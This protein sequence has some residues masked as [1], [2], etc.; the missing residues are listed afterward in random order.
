MNWIQQNI[1]TFGGD[2]DRV[3]IFGESNGA[4]AVGLHITAYG[5]GHDDPKLKP[6]FQ[7]GIMQSGGAT[8][9]AGVSSNTSFIHTA[10]VMETLNCTSSP[11]NP[12][13]DLACLR[14]L[15]VST[16]LSAAVNFQLAT[17][18]PF[19]FNVF[20]PVAPT[21]FIPDAPSTLLRTGQFAHNI[22]I[23]SGWNEDDGSLFVPP[24][25]NL[26]SETPTVAW[27]HTKYPGLT[28]SQIHTLLSL[29]P[30]DTPSFNNSATAD[31]ASGAPSQQYFRAS[32]MD[33][34]SSFTCPSLLTVSN[35]ARYSTSPLGSTHLYAL[36]SSLL[37]TDVYKPY[38]R[39]YYGISH[40]SDIPFAFNQVQASLSPPPPPAD[41][42]LSS[43]ISGAWLDFAT[44]GDPN[45][46]APG[47][48][49]QDWPKAVSAAPS[50]EPSSYTVQIFGGLRNGQTQLDGYEN[51]LAARC[52]F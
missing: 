19:G 22:N 26:T 28:Q 36:N 50:S 47:H 52:A 43:R 44:F 51:E 5:G 3:T 30:T 8:Q 45:G 39:S 17:R 37:Y 13:Q 29:Y 49:A 6:P 12:Q 10:A 11:P 42:K 35:M 31:L 24:P 18:P 20:D 2:P 7:Q 25:T 38:N 34:D 14:A 33:R 4:H 16:L 41:V 23:I 46:K 40:F 48:G 15:P 21:P 1:H 27:I 32:R 9:V